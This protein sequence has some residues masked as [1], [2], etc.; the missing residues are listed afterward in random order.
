[1][2]SGKHKRAAGCRQEHSFVRFDKTIVTSNF[3]RIAQRCENPGLYGSKNW[4]PKTKFDL[5]K[6]D[7]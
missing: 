3:A 5:F 1:M 4:L 6:I 7:E 2:A